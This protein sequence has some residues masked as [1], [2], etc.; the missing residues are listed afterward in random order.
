MK[1]VA[2]GVAYLRI[3]NRISFASAFFCLMPWLYYH[4]WER[5]WRYRN[6]MEM[7]VVRGLH[8]MHGIFIEFVDVT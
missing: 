8:E 3:R 2:S 7:L 1:R 6:T 5:S 4:L